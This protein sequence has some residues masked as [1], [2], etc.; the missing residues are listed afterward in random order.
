[1]FIYRDGT[2]PKWREEKEQCENMRS[3]QALGKLVFRAAWNKSHCVAEVISA[4]K[5][6]TKQTYD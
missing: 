2:C 5:V 6:A 3:K 1:M 4:V